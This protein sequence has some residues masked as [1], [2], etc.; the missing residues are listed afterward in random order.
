MEGVSVTVV[1]SSE[2]LGMEERT[3][4]VERGI[5]WSGCGVWACFA[6]SSMLAGLVLVLMLMFDPPTTGHPEADVVCAILLLLVVLLL[7]C[8][9]K[10]A[11]PPAD[12]PADDCSTWPWPCFTGQPPEAFGCDSFEFDA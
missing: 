1:E 8:L 12:A 7:F 9:K 5:V 6:A 2:G 4:W 3:R 10:D 11:H